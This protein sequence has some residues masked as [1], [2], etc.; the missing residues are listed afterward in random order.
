MIRYKNVRSD[1]APQHLE[2]TSESVLISSNIRQDTQYLEDKE[3][4]GYVY[5]YDEY[6]KN[7]YIRLLGEENERLNKE[8]LDTQDALCDIY[9][10]L[11]GGLG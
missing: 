11:E 6:G 7:E 2:I 8:L 10:M 9:E 3:I 5:D 1:Y 4:H